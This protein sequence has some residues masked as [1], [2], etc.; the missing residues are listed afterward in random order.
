MTTPIATNFDPA[1]RERIA[2]ILA[3][4]PPEAAEVIARVAERA[5]PRAREC[6]PW[7]FRIG[8]A[9][10]IHE[11]KILIG[12]TSTVDEDAALEACIRA[13]LEAGAAPPAPVDLA[14]VRA[15]K[16]IGGSTVG[17][18]CKDPLPCTDG[19]CDRCGWAMV[20]HARPLAPPVETHET[21]ARINAACGF[22]PMGDPP[23]R[24]TVVHPSP[25]DMAR[26][27]TDYIDS[28]TSYGQGVTDERVRTRALLLA[29][30]D[31]PVDARA[32]REMAEELR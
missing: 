32:L 11:V 18:P 22:S 26:E 8:M 7:A 3:T 10:W 2:A 9:T 6:A 30:A 20:T 15:S 25:A 28:E 1:L 4:L 23:Q 16:A 12:R 5:V 27:A 17:L 24:S 13:H 21:A 31:G 19:L 14:A 29:M